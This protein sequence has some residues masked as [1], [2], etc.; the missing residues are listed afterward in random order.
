MFLLKKFGNVLV[1]L[2][3][4]DREVILTK[5]EKGTMSI[6]RTEVKYNVNSDVCSRSEKHPER[7]NSRGRNSYVTQ[8]QP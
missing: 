1:S 6:E 3:E 2:F 8:G 7:I 5:S 4:F